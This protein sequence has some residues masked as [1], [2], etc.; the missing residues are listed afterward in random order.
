MFVIAFTKAQKEQ[1]SVFCYAQSAQI[2]KIRAKITQ[3]LQGE[4]SR[5]SLAELVK[6]LLVD[7]IEK[8]M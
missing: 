3:V 2:K 1:V 4:V 6:H 7:K 8:D 5:I